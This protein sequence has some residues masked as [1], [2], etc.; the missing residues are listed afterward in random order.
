MF[1][2]KPLIIAIAAATI[3]EVVVINK[4]SMKIARADKKNFLWEGH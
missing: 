3:I 1:K 2:F 4:E